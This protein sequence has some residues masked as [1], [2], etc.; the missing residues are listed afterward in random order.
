[1]FNVKMWKTL[2]QPL[3]IPLNVASSVADPEICQGGNDLRKL[4]PRVAAIFFWNSFDKG[5]GQACGA[6]WIRYC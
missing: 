5:G 3:K 1:M 2:S 6:P 4:Q